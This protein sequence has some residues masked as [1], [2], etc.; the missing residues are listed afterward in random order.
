VALVVLLLFGASLLGA[1]W[2]AVSGPQPA[3]DDAYEF[4]LSNGDTPVRWNPCEP[5]RYAVN[6]SLA[7]SGSLEDVQEAVRRVSAITGIPFEYEGLSPDV[8]SEN[9]ARTTIEGGVATWTPLLIGWVDPDRSYLDFTSDG[10]TAAGMATVWAPPGRGVY[11]TG[12]IA[13]NADDP[14]P[15]GFDI[16]G[17]QGVVLLHEL[18]H[19]IGLDHVDQMGELMEPSGGGVSDF[20]PGDLEGLRALGRSAGCLVTPRP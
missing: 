1:G 18:G 14:N 2:L 15:P 8:P 16:S 13:M 5:I 7:P 11:V 17:Q 19:I 6:V 3:P 4:I 12:W 20:G 9:R 10:H